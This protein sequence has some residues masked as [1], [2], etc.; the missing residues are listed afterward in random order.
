MW[1]NTFMF[2]KSIVPGHVYHVF[3]CAE[4]GKGREY[5]F[6]HLLHITLKIC[7]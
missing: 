4:G 3:L 2:I 1:F 6:M 5:N 7:F